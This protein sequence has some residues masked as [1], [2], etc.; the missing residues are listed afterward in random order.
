MARKKEVLFTRAEVD[1]ICKSVLAH[2]LTNVS[3]TL[4]NS[5]AEPSPEI[6]K[7]IMHFA[8]GA[9]VIGGEADALFHQAQ[10]ASIDNPAAIEKLKLLGEIIGE[11]TK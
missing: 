6:G 4:V 3:S 5:G 10:S 8:K 2:A 7:I 9:T 1:L 11:Q